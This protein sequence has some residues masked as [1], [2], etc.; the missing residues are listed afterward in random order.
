MASREA[1]IFDPHIQIATYWIKASRIDG[2]TTH[3]I[4]TD[5]DDIATTILHVTSTA[6]R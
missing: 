1:S 5:Y 6:A 4:P 2:Y 3:H